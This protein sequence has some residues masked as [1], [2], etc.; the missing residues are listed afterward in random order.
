MPVSVRFIGIDAPESR[1]PGGPEAT[2]A[3]R[4]LIGGRTVR[5]DFADPGGRKR[6]NFGRLLCRVFVGDLDV[7]P[8]M[9]RMGHAREWGP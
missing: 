8:E 1:D 7:G 6:D 4:A 5:L 3:L 9:L 2:A